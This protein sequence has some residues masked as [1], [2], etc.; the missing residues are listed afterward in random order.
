MEQSPTAYS[1]IFW[2]FTGAPKFKE[3]A[4]INRPDDMLKSEKIKRTKTDQEAIKILKKILADQKLL[5][6][7]QEKIMGNIKTKSF[8]CV[9]DLPLKDLKVHSQY[10][11]NVALGFSSEQIYK[12]FNPVLY[13]NYEKLELVSEICINHNKFD[14]NKIKN[15][16]IE[17]DTIINTR[18]SLKT[19][20][21]SEQFKNYIKLTDFNEAT[22]KT[23][24]RE[25]EWRC[26]EDFNFK[27]ADVSAVIV[28]QNFISPIE[29]YLNQK[30]F[31]NISIISWEIIEKS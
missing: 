22:E 24:Y 31:R 14:W 19:Q 10:Y 7:S 16:E 18:S 20:L 4:R 29:K 17:L 21:S 1:T 30:K 3:N 23:F 15:R 2:H 12:N 8:C 26:L 28:P 5:A 25:K 6:T 9:C 27:K 13:I 11:G